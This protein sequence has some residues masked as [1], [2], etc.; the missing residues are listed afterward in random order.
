MDIQV[1]DAGGARKHI[2]DHETYSGVDG[3]EVWGLLQR[4]RLTAEVRVYHPCAKPPLLR[5]ITVRVIESSGHQMHQMSGDHFIHGTCDQ[6]HYLSRIDLTT[7]GACSTE[8]RYKDV[9]IL[10]RSTKKMPKGVISPC[11]MYGR[12]SADIHG[13]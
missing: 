8:C 7:W 5:S 11:L 2:T 9:L 1:I 6:H 3:G 13:A 12:L 10:A 4:V